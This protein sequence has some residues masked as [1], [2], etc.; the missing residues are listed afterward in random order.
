MTGRDF[1]LPDLGEGLAEAEIVQWLVRPGDPVALNQP[2]VEVETAKAAVEI[3]S[4]YAGV[5]A[6]LHCAEGELVPVGTAL[7]TVAAESVADAATGAEEAPPAPVV[8]RAPVEPAP[9]EVPRRRPRRAA[10]T[11]L[12]A[13]AA[14]AP[15]QTAGPVLGAERRA[16]VARVALAPQRPAAP[17]VPAPN[18]LP[19]AKVLAAP[20]VRKLARDL[21]VDLGTVHPTGPNGTIARADVTAAATPVPD[22]GPPRPAPS[23]VRPGERLPVR[24]VARQMALAMEHSA[25]QVP[26]ATVQRTV[27]VT[28]LLDL[29]ARWRADPPAGQVTAGQAPGGDRPVRIT[30]LAFISRAVVAAVARHPLANARWLTAADGSNEIEV[31]PAVN[32]GVAVASER[33]LVVPVIPAA[34]RL[35]LTALAGELASLVEAARAG[36]T[37]PARMRGSTITV[38][39]V[40]VFGVDSAAGLVREGEAALVVLG[41][42]RDA[43]AVWQGEVQVRRVM[44]VSVSFDH[45]ILHGEAASRFLGEIAAVL[46]DPVSLLLHG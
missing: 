2:L 20:P 41:A 10:H 6:A 31:Y 18:G 29:L 24:G 25:F 19:R 36:R 40:G 27:D 14:A 46:A 13:A 12:V 44:T 3:P 5:V 30:S 23:G 17:L 4:P 42:I 11:G 1:L 33:G 32:L 28:G 7:L 43:A 16:P 22:P 26:Q 34:D 35:G 37:P 9:G 39:N 45:R 15:V 8:G 21:G 38:S